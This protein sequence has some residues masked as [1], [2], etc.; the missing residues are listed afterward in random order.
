MLNTATFNNTEQNDVH[1]KLSVSEKID[2]MITDD[3]IMTIPISSEHNL[4]SLIVDTPHEIANEHLTF[5]FDKYRQ[6]FT[7]HRKSDIK[8]GDFSI[9]QLIDY[10][11]STRLEMPTSINISTISKYLID[12]LVGYPDK[13]TQYGWIFKTID[14]SSFMADINSV[15][16]LN[17]ALY[18]FELNE[19]SKVV[20]QYTNQN[21]KTKVSKI[22][23]HLIFHLLHHTLKLINKVSAKIKNDPSKKELKAC[24]AYYTVGIVYRISSFVYEEVNLYGDQLKKINENYKLVVKSRESLGIKIENLIQELNKPK[25]PIDSPVQNYKTHYDPIVNNS[26]NE[27]CFYEEINDDNY[28]AEQGLDIENSQDY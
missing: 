15:I 20:E 3:P 17:K 19:L 21:T 16:R 13:R 7:V 14:Q 12:N 18:H 2:K 26:P 10:T 25:D 6:L 23:K 24:V 27:D 28:S 4:P 5:H 8:I 1:K 22:V 11:I 9:P